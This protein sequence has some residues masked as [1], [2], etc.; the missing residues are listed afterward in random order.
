M[1]NSVLQ[2]SSGDARIGILVSVILYKWLWL[3]FLLFTD[4]SVMSWGDFT[5]RSGH[6]KRNPFT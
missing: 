2:V 5:L 3:V 4:V 6:L 1:T